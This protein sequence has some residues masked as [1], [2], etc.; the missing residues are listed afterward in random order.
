P[1]ERLALWRDELT[2]ETAH[3]VHALLT[4]LLAGAGGCAGDLLAWDAVL[5]ALSQSKV[6][7]HAIVYEDMKVS[8][9]RLTTAEQR[10]QLRGHCQAVALDAV[11]ALLQQMDA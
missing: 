10:G 4:R 3:N 7:A 5:R 9:A 8:L 11:A 1:L 6:T 2:R